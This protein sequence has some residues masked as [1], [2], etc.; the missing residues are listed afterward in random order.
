MTAT[1]DDSVRGMGG[2]LIDLVRTR[3]PPHIH[4]GYEDQLFL[5][6]GSNDVLGQYQDIPVVQWLLWQW[7]HTIHTRERRLRAMNITYKHVTIPEKI[8]ICDDKLMGLD[9]EW[10][11]SP[12]Y[13]LYHEDPYY[14]RHPL[15]MA[16]LQQYLRR[17]SR[18][19]KTLIDLV[20]PMRR[21]RDDQQ[22]FHRTDTHWTFEGRLIGYHEICK[23]FGARPVRDFRERRTEYFADWSGD[24]GGVCEPKITEGATLHSLQRDAVRVHASPIVEHREK[25]GQ[26]QTLHTGSHVIYRNER[27]SD[28]RRMV[29]FGD[30]YSH[31]APIQ[32]TIMLA[33]TFRELHFI[34]S[35]Q[36]D[37]GYVERVKPD[38]VMTEMAERFVFR[39][40]S[41]EFDV[42]AYARERFGDELTGAVAGPAP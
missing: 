10:R 14:R 16:K 6:G 31:V 27:A 1:Q 40:P 37:Y 42:E 5:V 4:V 11:L 29:L 12:A 3:V 2:S 8:T 22:L 41:D 32:L 21:R 9:I 15:R 20:E 30:S 34:W 19:R 23:A 26:I 7:R 36:L 33:E 35:T 13:R 17:R 28:P 39:P 24:L 25:L 38:I 18:W